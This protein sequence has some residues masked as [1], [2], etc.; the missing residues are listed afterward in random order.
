[1]EPTQVGPH[2]GV[3]VVASFLCRECRFFGMNNAQT[4]VKKKHGYKWRCPW[5]GAKWRPWAERADDIKAN[6]VF[7]TRN[8]TTGAM[9]LIPMVFPQNVA[10][11]VMDD[12]LDKL[13]DPEN[14]PAHF[15]H[16]PTMPMEAQR[17]I[18][19]GTWDTSHQMTHGFYGAKFTD[20]CAAQEPYF[21]WNELIGLITN[22]VVT[23]RGS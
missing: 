14:I 11:N 1:M 5:C 10:A 22:F 16:Y 18:D 4:W 23:G 21:D 17:R 13:M 7:S 8:P 3:E 2:E 20:T 9:D 12:L 19:S 15:E 6:F